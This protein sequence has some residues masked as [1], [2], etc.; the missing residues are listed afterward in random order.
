MTTNEFY[1][2]LSNMNLSSDD[3]I[4][5]ICDYFDSNIFEGLLEHIKNEY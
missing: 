1:N 3:L 5:I 4:N 2:E